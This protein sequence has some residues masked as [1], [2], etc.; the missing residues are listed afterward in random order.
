MIE[1]ISQQSDSQPGDDELEVNGRRRNA[2]SVYCKWLVEELKRKR[3]VSRAEFELQFKP[4]KLIPADWSRVSRSVHATLHAIGYDIVLDRSTKLILKNSGPRRF[5]NRFFQPNELSAEKNRIGW[6][7]AHYL[8]KQANRHVLLGSGS[9]VFHVGRNM[10]QIAA[11]VGQYEQLF[12]TVNIALAALWCEDNE[13][14]VDR[15]QIPKGELRT[16]TFRY[17]S[18]EN[19]DWN[20]PIAV[21]GADGCYLHDS[22]ASLYANETSVAHNTNHFAS[23]ALDSVICCIVSEKL[24]Y[25]RSLGQNAGPPIHG[26]HKEPEKRGAIKWFLVTD[27]KLDPNKHPKIRALA[28]AGWKIVADLPDWTEKDAKEED[29][30][31]QIVPCV[32]A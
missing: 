5:A 32:F 23:R 26:P 9:T 7:V 19:P 10:Q 4:D 29:L 3:E 15:L 6:L 16:A 17:A 13:S 24:I 31:E 25:D 1:E 12:W 30:V 27:K 22:V 11:K 2:L 28:D 14:P 21:V 18:M 8:K 20:C